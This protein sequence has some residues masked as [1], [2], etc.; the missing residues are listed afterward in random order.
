M[1]QRQCDLCAIFRHQV[2][3]CANGA[4]ICHLGRE[5]LGIPV[6]GRHSIQT[7]PSHPNQQRDQRTKQGKQSCPDPRFE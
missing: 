5:A 3:D 7:D 2:A 4:V 6:S 1:L